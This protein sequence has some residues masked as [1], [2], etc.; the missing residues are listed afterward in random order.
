MVATTKGQLKAEY[1]IRYFLGPI[2][3]HQPLQ[4]QCILL[5]Q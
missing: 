3:Q 4:L 2:K 5:K 1:L